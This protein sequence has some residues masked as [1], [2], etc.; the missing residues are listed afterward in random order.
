MCH[1]IK[2]VVTNNYESNKKTQAIVF[3]ENITSLDL[4]DLL[5]FQGCNRCSAIPNAIVVKLTCIFFFKGLGTFR[6][7]IAQVDLGCIGLGHFE[8]RIKKGD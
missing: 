4:L 8:L 1:N 3:V 2:L 5:C 7:G 6:N